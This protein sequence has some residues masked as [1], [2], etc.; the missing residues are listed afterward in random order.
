MFYI[1]YKYF[2]VVDMIS[3][4]NSIWHERTFASIHV[5]LYILGKSVVF[6]LIFKHWHVGGNVFLNGKDQSMVNPTA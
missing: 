4:I 2:L 1:M 5:S 6:A 3:S